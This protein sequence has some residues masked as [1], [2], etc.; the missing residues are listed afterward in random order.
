MMEEDDVLKK[1]PGEWILLINDEIVE[2]CVDIE[3]MLR[4]VDEKYPADKFPGDNIKISKVPQG[5]P[6]EF[7][8]DG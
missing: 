2:H 3:D 7:L 6:R 4:L 1:Y 8:H 5:S